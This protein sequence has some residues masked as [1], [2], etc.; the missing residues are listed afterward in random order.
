MKLDTK[1]LVIGG[2][3]LFAIVT[4][5]TTQLLKG[6]T[7]TGTG[8]DNTP[9][10]KD[11]E[12]L[13]WTTQYAEPVMR[14]LRPHF[15]NIRI[16]SAYRSEAVNTAVGGSKTS[17]HRYGLGLDF[18]GIGLYD[19][20]TRAARF[21]RDNL[22]KLPQPN[23]VRTVIGETNHLHMDFY[24]P[25]GEYDSQATIAKRGTKFLAEP[26]EGDFIALV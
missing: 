9:T 13:L 7:K 15:P 12:R 5:S 19:E 8:L 6:F 14:M 2:V 17:R 3:A 24:D 25:L 11:R 22:D 10:G 4:Y 1:T 23:M 21:V 16:T 26:T 18:G 20:T